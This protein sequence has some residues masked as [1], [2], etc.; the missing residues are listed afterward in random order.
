MDTYRIDINREDCIECGSCYSLDP[1]HFESD[2]GGKA[3]VVSGETSE[4][5]SLG[6]FDDDQIENAKEAQDYCAVS[7]V[8]VK[9]M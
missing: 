5:W 8:T 3:H 2:N 7:V 9:I 1:T 4:K 6:T